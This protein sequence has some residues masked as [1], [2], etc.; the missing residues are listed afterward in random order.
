MKK[1]LSLLLLGALFFT[2]VQCAN[3]KTYSGYGIAMYMSDNFQYIQPAPNPK[4]TTVMSAMDYSDRS[5]IN[6]TADYFKGSEPT[7]SQLYDVKNYFINNFTNRGVSV[8]DNGLFDIAGG[9]RGVYVM[10]TRDA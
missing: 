1:I 7:N 4:A 9:H 2:K 3:A 8:V 10:K 5:N 6:L